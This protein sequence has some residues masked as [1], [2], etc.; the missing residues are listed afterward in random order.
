MVEQAWTDINGNAK[1]FECIP[2]DKGRFHPTEKPIKLYAWLLA[3]YAKPGWKIL[4]THMG[5]GT[6][7]I[8]RWDAGYDLTASEINTEYFTKAIARI[9]DHKRERFL[10][11]QQELLRA[12][13]ASRTLFDEV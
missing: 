3:M 12:Q 5:S 8:A 9:E 4:D 13:S 10:F 6:I 11:D 7:A 2:Q 1:Y